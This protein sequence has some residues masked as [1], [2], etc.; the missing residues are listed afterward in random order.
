MSFRT[1]G[2]IRGK[3]L[4]AVGPERAFGNGTGKGFWQ[5][6]RKSLLAMGPERAK[7]AQSLICSDD[8]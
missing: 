7:N 1:N 3:E 6:D 5:W 4:L 2:R 8:I